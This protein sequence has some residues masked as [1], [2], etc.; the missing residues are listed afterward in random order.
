MR[1]RLVPAD[2]GPPT[3][4]PRRQAAAAPPTDES[5]PLDESAEPPQRTT[6]ATRI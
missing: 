2:G 4:A 5:I 3:P 1:A 6:R